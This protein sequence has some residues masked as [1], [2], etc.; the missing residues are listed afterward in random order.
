MSTKYYQRKNL[1]QKFSDFIENLSDQELREKLKGLIEEKDKLVDIVAYSLMPTHIHFILK[2]LDDAGISRFM[3]NLLN[4]YTRYFNL[5][6]G[7][8]GPLWQGRFMSILV[9]RDSQLLHLTRYVHLNPTT[10]G[11]VN[12]PEDWSYSSYREYLKTIPPEEQMC[13]YADLIDLSPQ[14]YR[15]FVEDRISYQ[16][17]LA[18]IK[19][20][21]L[22]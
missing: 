17:E 2:Q 21:T 19:H 13:A 4:S 14:D 1:P 9:E 10:A 3:S 15:K 18:V 8:K 5:T 20:L 11:I 12:R 22:E 7:R 16:K 6:H